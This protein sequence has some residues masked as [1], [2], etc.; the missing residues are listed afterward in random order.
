MDEWFE[1]NWFDIGLS[2]AVVVLVGGVLIKI[3]CC[4]CCK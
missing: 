2:V 3:Y 4:K 1:D